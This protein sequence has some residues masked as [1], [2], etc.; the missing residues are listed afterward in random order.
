MNKIISLVLFLLTNYGSLVASPTY[1]DFSDY[2]S[3]MSARGRPKVLIVGCG[4][5]NI[6]SSQGNHKHK[7]CWCVDISNPNKFDDLRDYNSSQT[8]SVERVHFLNHPHWKSTF[9]DRELDIT[10]SDDVS[11]Y[12]EAFDTI[13]LERNW[14]NTL[15]NPRTLYNAMLMLKEGGELVIDTN[16]YVLIYD[17]LI[18]NIKSAK[19]EE[20]TPQVNLSELPFYATPDN[21]IFDS[22]SFNIA[23]INLGMHYNLNVLLE[24]NLRYGYSETNLP[25]YGVN[26]KDVVNYL[27]YWHFENVTSFNECPQ[28]FT[29]SENKKGRVSPNLIVAIKTAYTNTIKDSWLE[30]IVDYERR[31]KY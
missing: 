13:V 8:L 3:Q 29:A 1:K 12:E 6:T 2:T 18:T 5:L 22:N 23:A 31:S 15:N 10:N 21:K 14:A 24:R 16:N 17:I 25:C 20:K 28:P 4:H 7:D 9:S 27:N 19:A 30:S 26:V 11:G